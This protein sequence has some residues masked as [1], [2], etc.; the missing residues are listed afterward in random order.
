MD[1]NDQKEGWEREQSWT[2]EKQEKVGKM[3]NSYSIYFF[4]IASLFSYPIYHCA[5]S[6]LSF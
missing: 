5:I 6:L 3:K 1:N 4:K 2:Q